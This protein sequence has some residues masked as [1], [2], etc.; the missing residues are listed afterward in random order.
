MTRDESTIYELLRFFMV[1]FLVEASVAMWCAIYICALL[2]RVYGT[3]NLGSPGKALTVE[4]H[5]HK[6]WVMMMESSRYR[7]DFIDVSTKD[8]P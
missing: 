6:Q 8:E 5:L 2:R 7:D 3:L 4:R 1:F